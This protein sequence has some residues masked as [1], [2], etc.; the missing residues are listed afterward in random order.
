MIKIVNSDSQSIVNAHVLEAR[1]E[2]LV[3]T[4]P[5]SFFVILSFKVLNI[6]LNNVHIA[7]FINLLVNPGRLYGIFGLSLECYGI[8]LSIKLTKY[9]MTSSACKP[10]LLRVRI[11]YW[12][13][14]NF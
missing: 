9:F 6:V 3:N 8:D 1:I 13:G 10:K 12:Q 5:N 4:Y 11:K 2:E 7:S 14:F